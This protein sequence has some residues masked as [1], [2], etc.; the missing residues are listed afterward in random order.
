MNIFWRIRIKNS[1]ALFG[2]IGFLSGFN[3]V[4]EK[5]Y[6]SES[7]SES[8][9]ESKAATR[10]S[11]DSS[12]LKQP[13]SRKDEEK[14]AKE[15]SQ[16]KAPAAANKATKQASIR[17]FFQKKWTS[18]SVFVALLPSHTLMTVFIVLDFSTITNQ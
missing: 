9:D 15:K 11:E 3:L 17:G 7:Y 18:Y 8:E 4:T 10:P 6:E 2:I 1:A 16:K 5:G 13:L 12:S 14:K